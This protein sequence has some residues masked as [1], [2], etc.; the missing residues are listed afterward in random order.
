MINQGVFSVAMLNELLKSV[1]EPPQRDSYL[2]PFMGNTFM[3]NTFG[4]IPIR[5]SSLFPY[6]NACGKCGG[7][8]D[9]GEQSTY[10]QNCKGGGQIKYNGTMIQGEQMIVLVEYYPRK[11]EPSFPFALPVRPLPVY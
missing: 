5:S 7:T 10:C 1:Q 11:F 9:G 6:T 3:G 2:N 4:G 8:G